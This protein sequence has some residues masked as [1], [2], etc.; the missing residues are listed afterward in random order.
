MHLNESVA[1]YAKQVH[2]STS[3]YSN[4]FKKVTGQSVL[5][6]VVSERIEV[7]KKLILQGMSL[8]EVA[9]TVGYHERS[10]FSDVFKKKVGMSPSDFK[11]KYC[12]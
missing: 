8:Q 10:Y 11:K 5:Q 12:G 6:F 7:A 4:L 1:D 2:L 9:V 3:Y